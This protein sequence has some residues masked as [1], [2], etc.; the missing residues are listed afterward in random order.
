MIHSFKHLN[1]IPAI[2]HNSVQIAVWLLKY[3]QSVNKSSNTHYVCYVK[4]C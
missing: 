3:H 4:L 2:K 1:C